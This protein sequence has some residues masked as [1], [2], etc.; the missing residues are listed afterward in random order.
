M[1]VRG[2]QLRNVPAPPAPFPYNRTDVNH[3]QQSPS[4]HVGSSPLGDPPGYA[5]GGQRSPYS[6]TV[7]SIVYHPSNSSPT[8]D[9]HR[10]VTKRSTSLPRKTSNGEVVITTQKIISPVEDQLAAKAQ[11]MAQM[12]KDFEAGKSS[13]KPADGEEGESKE[14]ERAPEGVGKENMSS[15]KQMFEAQ[16]EAREIATEQREEI[17]SLKRSE[18]ER[19]KILAAFMEEEAKEPPKD[20]HI[21]GKIVY[22]VERVIAAK[23]IYHNVCFKCCKCSKKLTPTTFNSHE[24]SLYC[25]AHYNEALHPEQVGALL[26]AD[27]EDE[28]ERDDEEFALV[29]KPKQLASD[30][31]RAGDSTNIG[32]ELAQLRSLKGKEG[33]AGAIAAGRVR[34]FREKIATGG[35]SEANEDETADERRKDL[36][37][38]RDSVHSVK[39]KWKTGDVE[40][41]EVRDLSTKDEI[42]ELR[43]G[44]KVSDRFKEGAHDETVVKRF[45]KSELDTSAAAEARRSFL[46]GSAF[47]EET[48]A[49]SRTAS[50]KGIGGDEG[51][52]EKTGIELDIQLKS[53]KESLN[54]LHDEENMT[55]EE[56]AEKKKKEIEEEFLRYK[57]ARKLQEKRAQQGGGQAEDEARDAEGKSPLDVE[58]GMAGK[59]RERFREIDAQNPGAEESTAEVVN[60][61]VVDDQSDDEDA[62]AFDVKN[63]MNKFKNLQNA[64]TKIEKNL[65]ELEALRVAADHASKM[66]A[67]WEKIQKKEAKKAEKSKD[68]AEVMP[69]RFAHNCFFI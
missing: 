60:R 36:E 37:A 9:H 27:G 24:G 18:A 40:G 54:K 28:V 44:P 67:K 8:S 62:D 16:P 69:L 53:I 1:G 68:A 57:I 15:M 17:G 51:E 41:A 5:A 26:D 55:P 21:C 52:H 46:E 33:R 19:K 20:C 22:P 13:L 29:S 59:A 11:S 49:P 35:D 47:H 30:V 14:V 63:L 38:I 61:R 10:V 66:A 31:V 58:I 32:D 64:P 56:R 34:E 23:N 65:D 45:D 2:S 25:R 4:T 43:R 7:T 3:G 50:K 12:K 6:Q 48:S 39:N 42:E